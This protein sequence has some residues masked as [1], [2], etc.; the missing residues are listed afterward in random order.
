LLYEARPAKSFTPQLIEAWRARR[1]D[2]ALFFSPRTAATFVRLARSA[3]LDG[4]GVSAYA[5]SP[6]VA[7]TL[8]SLPWGAVRVAGQPTQEALLAAI[9][10]DIAARPAA[11]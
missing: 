4:A 5:L 10:A 6:A 3:G 8:A 11:N 2:I 9:D 7:G 1:I